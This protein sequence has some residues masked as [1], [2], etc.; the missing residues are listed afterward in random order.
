MSKRKRKATNRGGEAM[1]PWAANQAEYRKKPV[2]MPRAAVEPHG[3]A[4][5]LRVGELNQRVAGERPAETRS[6]RR[7]RP[8]DI[9]ITDEYREVARLIASERPVIFVTGKAGTGKS[10]LISYLRE[11]VD[12]RLAVVAPTGVAALQARGV[13]IHSFFRFPPRILGQDEIG[14]V[15][16]GKI[17][18]ALELLIID[19]ISMV[20]ADVLDAIDTF[21]RINGRFADKPFGGIKVLMV[22]DLLQLPPVVARNEEAILRERAYATPFFFSAKC[23]DQ[24]EMA[25]VELTKIF[26]QYFNFYTAGN[27]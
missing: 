25:S 23:L 4:K 21:L 18:A 26:R 14:K 3:R 8:A 7:E 19:E 15:Q 20:R 6:P 2:N 1:P 5:L 13:T 22:G 10:T 11:T 17:Y 9:E 27:G 12:R 24:C 16:R